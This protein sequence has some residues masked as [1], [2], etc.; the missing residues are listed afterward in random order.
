[1]CS[2]KKVVVCDVL[3]KSKC[4][5]IKASVVVICVNGCVW[6]KVY[7]CFGMCLNANVKCYCKKQV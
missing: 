2:L 1:M 3:K 6:F 7:V 5:K 4:S